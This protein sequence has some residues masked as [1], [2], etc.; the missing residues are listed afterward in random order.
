MKLLNKHVIAAVASLCLVAGFAGNAL[1]RDRICFTT[2]DGRE[3]CI[4]IPMLID[5]RWFDP[6]PP[7]PLTPVFDPRL[8]D[9]VTGVEG[10]LPDPWSSDLVI[11]SNI[12]VLAQGLSEGRR[13]ALMGSL[14]E[15]QKSL[16]AE[17]PAG[18]RIVGP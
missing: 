8:I 12:S 11:I 13:E 17:L 5:Y 15:A 3:I 1:A 10:P 4:W 2:A 16:A 18:A 9:L 14:L 6:N 7:D